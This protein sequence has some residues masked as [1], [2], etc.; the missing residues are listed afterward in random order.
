MRKLAGLRANLKPSASRR[1]YRRCSGVPSL[2]WQA[3]GLSASPVACQ[4]GGRLTA[5]HRYPPAD[6]T[7]LARWEAA[8]V[9]LRLHAQHVRRL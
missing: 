7:L 5:R 4:P 6:A 1:R 8:E 3:P 9:V 2:R